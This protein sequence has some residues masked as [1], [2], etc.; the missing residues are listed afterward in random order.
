MNIYKDQSLTPAITVILVNNSSCAKHCEGRQ[1]KASHSTHTVCHGNRLWTLENTQHQLNGKS[2]HTMSCYQDNAC[3]CAHVPVCI[4]EHVCW[5]RVC[6][7]RYTPGTRS[8]S[9]QTIL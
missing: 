3:A 9:L 7:I 4:Y 6:G 8:L 5:Q 1:L 2:S